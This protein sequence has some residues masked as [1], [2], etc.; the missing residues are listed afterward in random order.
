MTA[1]FHKQKLLT[2]KRPEIFELN[3]KR[4]ILK[5]INNLA[6]FRLKMVAKKVKFSDMLS[7][8]TDLKSFFAKPRSKSF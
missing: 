6:W 7:V 8:Q 5:Y 4:L 3:R 2:V 1:E